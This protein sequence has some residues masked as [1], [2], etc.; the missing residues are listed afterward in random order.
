MVVTPRSQNPNATSIK[1]SQNNENSGIGD[2][3]YKLQ[4]DYKRLKANSKEKNI[5]AQLASNLN[6]DPLSLF[7]KGERKKT[8]ELTMES[9]LQGQQKIEKK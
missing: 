7:F 3:I 4:S 9:L 6:E 5:K 1:L 2:D 8:E